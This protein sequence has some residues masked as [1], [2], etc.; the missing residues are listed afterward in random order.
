M[1]CYYVMMDQHPHLASKI[2][3]VSAL[4][5]ISYTTHATGLLKEVVQLL[6]SLPNF[7]TVISRQ[8]LLNV[9]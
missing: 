8:D 1:T 3:L 6:V 9:M 4:S 5:P 7:M 2:S